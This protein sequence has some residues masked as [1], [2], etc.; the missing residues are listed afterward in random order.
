MLS[1]WAKRAVQSWVIEGEAVL[2]FE[3][4]GIGPFR[5]YSTVTSFVSCMIAYPFVLRLSLSVLVCSLF[6]HSVLTTS[7]NRS[8]VEL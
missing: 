3:T 4:G 7:M 1:R 6:L 8:R 2:R 5:V